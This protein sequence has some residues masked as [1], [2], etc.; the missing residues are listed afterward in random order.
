MSERLLYIDLDR[1]DATYLPGEVLTFTCRA[2][3]RREVVES[4]EVAVLWRTEGKGDENG[5][6][7]HSLRLTPGARESED[8]Q[9]VEV[10][11][12]NSPLSYDGVL[13]KIHWYVRVVA[14]VAG[15]EEVQ[16]E[17]PFRLGTVSP[18]VKRT[19]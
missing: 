11:L 9:R 16:R 2:N 18:S 8:S 19:L 4:L 17:V 7:V 15:G 1:K 5:D 6:V 10:R 13:F 14:L 12:P 3:Q